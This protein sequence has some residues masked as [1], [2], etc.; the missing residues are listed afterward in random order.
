MH[1]AAG[2]V[3]VIAGALAAAARKRPGRHPRAGTVYLAGHAVVFVTATAMTAIRPREDA[4]LSAIALTAAS[5]GWY[6]W[7]ARRSRRP[8][9]PR[10]H[11]IAMG[12]SYI[13]LLTGFYVDNGSQLPLW[14]RLP[15]LANWLAP[16]VV[17]VPLIWW[18]LRRY[19]AGIGARARAASPAPRRD[20]S[21][22]ETMP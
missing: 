15:H 3:A 8:G 19:R 21:T 17:G 12:G 10:R 9:W 22:E 7:R 1:V 11:A 13:V 4:L 16:A 20:R 14:D 18:A 5:L 6:G 2:F